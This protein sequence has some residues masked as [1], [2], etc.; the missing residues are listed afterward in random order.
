[1]EI[2]HET[3]RDGSIGIETV[4]ERM[5]LGRS[6]PFLIFYLNILLEPPSALLYV[7]S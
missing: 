1:M 7:T 6:N 3:R 5:I 2:L 4:I